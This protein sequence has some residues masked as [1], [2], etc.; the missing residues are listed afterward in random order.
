M[1]IVRLESEMLVVIIVRV[2]SISDAFHDVAPLSSVLLATSFIYHC[3]MPS[4]SPP[5]TSVFRGNKSFFP[6]TLTGS[7]RLSVELL[8][9]MSS[10]ARKRLTVRCGLSTFDQSHPRPTPHMMPPLPRPR[11]P[12]LEP[13]PL[14]LFFATFDLMLG[15]C[16]RIYVTS[17]VF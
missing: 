7:P 8:T 11:H 1:Y 2:P 3:L 4:T 10:I 14:F 12:P 9:R 6:G 16:S 15:E 5:L 13:G 17:I